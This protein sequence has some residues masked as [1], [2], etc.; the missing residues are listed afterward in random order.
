MITPRRLALL[1]AAAAALATAGPA[2]PAVQDP[3]RDA[4]M[5]S[6]REAVRRAVSPGEGEGTARSVILFV[7]DGMGLSTVTAARI[8]E[9]QR[10]GGTG[11][12]NL[13]HFERLPFV[14]LAKVYSVDRQVPDSAST[15]TAMVTGVKTADAVLSMDS[16]AV[17]AAGAA[18][19]APQRS[20]PTLLELFEA[21]GRSTGVVSTA[22][23][24]HATPAACYAHSPDRGWESD[25]EVP[26]ADAAAGA[27]DIARQL[28]EWEGRPGDGLEV[29]MGGGRG[30]F[31]PES[32]ADHEDPLQKGHRKDGRD[33]TA[34]WTRRFPRSAY[35]WNREQL[36]ALDTSRTDHLLALFE[37]SHMEYE[38]DRG[39]DKGG[40]PSLARMTER[41]IEILRRNPEGFFLMVEGGRID[42][43]HHVNN[44]YRALDETIAFAAAVEAARRMTDPKD[45]LVVVTAD[46]SHVMTIGGHPVR[47]N[48]ILGY[49]REGEG[50]AG[51]A[52]GRPYTTLG[53]ANGPGAEQPGE[54]KGVSGQEEDTASP[55]YR[56]RAMVPLGSESHAG[57]DVPVYAGGAGSR[58]FRGVV[59][60]HALFHLMLEAAGMGERKPVRPGGRRD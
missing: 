38:A 27:R 7:G 19:F 46:H 12:E 6:G 57:E 34:E 37:R 11:E 31:L 20:L 35:V 59:E 21:R 56:Q 24:T 43:A 1:A 15:I 4:W 28:V 53:Y 52:G 50:L 17:T 55:E 22:R 49:V 36:E 3:G 8:L 23:L 30:A 40:E 48:P 45:T 39:R 33:L 41:A 26:A 32:A 47:G 14:A 5:E 2:V 9:G 54:T 44:A 13:L 18:R 51:D 60:Q 58:L 25:A 10:R 29:A 16:A 42:H